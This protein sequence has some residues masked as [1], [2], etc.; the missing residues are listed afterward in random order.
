MDFFTSYLN[1]RTQFVQLGNIESSHLPISFGVPQGSILGPLLFLIFINDLPN[2]TDFYIKLFADDTFLCAQNDDI[3][4]LEEEVNVQINK[5]YQWLASNKLT[6][7]IS[8]SKFM[9]ISNKKRIKSNFN[10]SINDSPLEKCDN[11]KYL[12]VIIDNKLNWKSH[13]E[14]ISTKISK[15]C[16][17]LSKLRHCLSSRVLIEIYHALVHSYVRYGILTWGNASDTTLKPLQALINRA[18]RIMTF[19]PFGRIDLKPIYKELKILDIK[20]TLF[21]ETGK[22]M[23][24]VKNDIVPVRV[25]NYFETIDY[26]SNANFSHNLRSN[27]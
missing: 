8:K 24:K 7:N 17:V 22:F 1:S 11:Y 13:V 6:L 10:V 18:V 26:P 9:I 2:A 14:Y 21:L 20:S 5:V 4:L 25:A 15:A 27:A 23:F 12:G 3:E 19:A 16:G